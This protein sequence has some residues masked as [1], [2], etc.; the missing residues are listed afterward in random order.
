VWLEVL[1]MVE[2]LLRVFLHSCAAAASSA[3]P[4]SSSS[5][6]QSEAIPG[7]RHGAVLSCIGT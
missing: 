6:E 2:V 3:P 4:L 7:V 5:K 1:L